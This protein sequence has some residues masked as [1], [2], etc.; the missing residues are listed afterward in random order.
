MRLRTRVTSRSQLPKQPQPRL[1]TRVRLVPPEPEPELRLDSNQEMELGLRERAAEARAKLHELCRSDVNAFCEYVLRDQTGAQFEQNYFHVELH[2]ALT[3]H[4]QIVVVSHPETGKALTLDTEIPTPD[5]WRTMGSLKTGDR[6]FGGDG[7]P[8]RVTFA[9]PVQLG[10]RVF[11]VEFEDGAVLKADA[12]HQWHVRK[13]QAF[14]TRVVTTLDMLRK[15]TESD[16]HFVWSVPCA[17]AA[18]YERMRLPIAPYVLGAWLGDGTASAAALTFCEADSFV[19]DQCVGM[20]GGRTPRVDKRHVHVKSGTLGSEWGNIRGKLRRLRVLNDKHIPARYLT[21]SVRDRRDLLAGLLDTDGSVSRSAGGSSRV[22]LTLCNERLAAD[23]L[24]LIRSLGFRAT[25]KESDARLNGRVVGRRWRICFTARTP[26][27]RLPRKLAKQQ[28]GGST[29][30]QW[31]HV[32]AIREIESVPVR[33]I[34]VDSKDRTY[35]AGRSYT[36]THN[37]SQ[38]IGR[39]LWELGRNPNLRVMLLYNAEEAAMNT[40]SSIKKYIEESDELRAVFPNLRRGSVWK[41]DSIIVARTVFDRNPS[42]I[43]VGYNSRRI[44][45]SRIDLLIVDDLLDQAVTGTEAQR[46]KLSSWV[47]I[48]V[49]TRLAAEAMVAFLTNAWHPRDLAH[50]L[51][52]ERGWHQLK[53]PIRNPDGAIWWSWWTE[54]RLRQKRKDLGPLEYARSFECNP[55]DDGSRVFR[56]EHVEYALERGK[57]YGFIHSLDIMPDRCL[58]VTGVDLAAGDDTKKQ[59]ARTALCSVFFHPNQDRQVARLRSG[60]WRARQILEELG[61]VGNLFPR[62]HWIVVENNGVQRWIL[63][64]ANENEMDVGV[65]LV[66]FQTGRNKTDPRLGVASMSAEYESKRWILPSSCETEEEQAE[67]ESLV[68]Q[69]I[70]YVPEAHTGDALMAKWM[71]REIG[72]KIFARFFG[73]GATGGSIVRSIG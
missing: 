69:M 36:V 32:V 17:G 38:A 5:G 51:V 21:A 59:G 24:E 63:D 12:D 72:R 6:V 26:V 58:V 18:Q 49:F 31:K 64:L 71:A 57:G 19:W 20:V 22:E 70:D 73:S 14:G 7:A 25:M 33:C 37:T 30:T 48:T 56:P 1:R 46:R 66:P 65:A 34:A 4:R 13:R 61:I 47:K 10:R 45:G 54:E 41:D 3:K 8:C 44:G 16:G 40:L 15:L 52:K 67:V 53:R 2:E 27:F 60:R 42:V 35:L 39:V 68:S 23:S 55:R 50:E 9:T 29:R 11:E 43:A 62:N 28:L